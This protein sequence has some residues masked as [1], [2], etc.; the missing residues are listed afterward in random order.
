VCVCVCV[1]VCVYIYIY[2]YI[3]IYMYQFT[4]GWPIM[5]DI[6]LTLC[7]PHHFRRRDSKRGLLSH[8][9]SNVRAGHVATKYSARSKQCNPHSSQTED[10]S[11]AAL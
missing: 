9:C 6:C 2:I 10:I 3:H 8:Y 11:S 1:C 7:M 5:A 4:C